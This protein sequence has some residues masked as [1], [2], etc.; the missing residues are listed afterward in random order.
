MEGT[1]GVE[2]VV[3]GVVVIP[4]RVVDGGGVVVVEGSVTTGGMVA[5]GERHQE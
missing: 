5:A 4:G 2:V 1:S 3:R